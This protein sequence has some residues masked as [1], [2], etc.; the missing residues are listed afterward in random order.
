[1]FKE[2]MKKLLIAIGLLASVLILSIT[3]ISVSEARV[4]ETNGNG[5][6]DVGICEPVDCDTDEGKQKQERHYEDCTYSCPVV[7]FK[8]Y[9]TTYMV[10]YNKSNDP[11]KCH[12]PSQGELQNKYGMPLFARLDFLRRNPEFRR[13]EEDCMSFTDTQFIDC[14]V[15][16]E[17]IIP[18]EPCEPDPTP[19]PEPSP[20]PSPEPTPEP[21]PEP[22]VEPKKEA[23]PTPRVSHRFSRPAP[24]KAPTCD[25]VDP[26]KEPANPHLYRN[27][28]QAIIKWHPT[29]GRN[30]HIYY[31]E[32]SASYWQHAVRDIE[33]TGYFIIIGLGNKDWDFAIQQA[34]GCAAGPMSSVIFDDVAYGVLFRVSVLYL[35]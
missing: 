1:M 31:K 32:G 16:P 28:D 11:H 35:R 13:A 4:N 12:R 8:W 19:T 22:T 10:E 6:E 33:N 5:W 2:S 30:A 20:E 26:T 27:G 34:N 25:E 14:T 3:L 18:C 15:L 23:T 24:A 7:E 29:E 21:S 17:N 9:G